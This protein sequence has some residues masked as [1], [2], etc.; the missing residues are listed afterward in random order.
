MITSFAGLP[1]KSLVF[2]ELW[3]YIFWIQNPALKKIPPQPCHSEKQSFEE[4]LRNL[5]D[6]LFREIFRK[7]V[8]THFARSIRQY[9]PSTPARHSEAKL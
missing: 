9:L 7:G 1:Y 5:N 6:R 2:L 8:S 4:S 3:T